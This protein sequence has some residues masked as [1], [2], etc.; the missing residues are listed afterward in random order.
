MKCKRANPPDLVRYS[1]ALSAWAP[2]L[3][4]GVPQ[5]PS[6]LESR[7]ERDGDSFPPE[8]HAGQQVWRQSSA[9]PLSGTARGALHKLLS[10]TCAAAHG[11]TGGS[12]TSSRAVKQ[13]L[14]FTA[15]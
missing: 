10:Y 12:V 13:Q 15:R 5:R 8:A 11:L 9:L 4:V 6:R 14:A 1:V 7:N 3:Y 2:A